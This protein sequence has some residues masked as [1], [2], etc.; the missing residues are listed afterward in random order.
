MSSLRARTPSGGPFVV[1]A[2]L[3][4]LACSGGGGPDAGGEAGDSGASSAAASTEGT[5]SHEEGG[6][7]TH[8]EGTHTHAAADT[9]DADVGL[10]PGPGAGWTG[11][12]T[13][14]AVGDSLRVLVSV[15][16]AAGGSRHPAELR[17]GSCDEPGPELV[18]LT[19]LAAGSSGT[20]SSE[21]TVPAARLGDHA[22]GVLRLMDTDGSPTACAP[23]HL[24]ASEHTHG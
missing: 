16:G 3:S 8:G 10:E 20:G 2:C 7:H 22:H 6:D 4:L 17:A 21:T 12:A 18:T 1:A 19:P 15:D 24:S 23:V 11:S 14:L 9:L 5:H 13:V